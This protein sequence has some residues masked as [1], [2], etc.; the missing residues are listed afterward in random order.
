MVPIRPMEHANSKRPLRLRMAYYT[1]AKWRR[2]S[3]DFNN[4]TAAD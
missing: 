4:V 1:A 2:R 3:S